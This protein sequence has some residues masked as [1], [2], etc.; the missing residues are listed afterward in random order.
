MTEQFLDE[1]VHITEIRSLIGR[2]LGPSQPTILDQGRI[3]L[4]ADATGDR[5]WIHTDPNRAAE[6]ATG[7]TIAHGFLILALA[8]TVN[9]E[10]VPIAGTASR[11]NYGLNKVR[12]ISPAPAGTTARG[13]TTLESVESVASGTQLIFEIEI[14]GD[15]IE[16]PLCIA[17]FIS[18][19]PG[20]HL[21]QEPAA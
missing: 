1:A 15:E 21:E 16:K 3:D 18:L 4:F 2:R 12:F 19:A 8:A 7:S 11:V 9:Q 20:V 5:Q 13:Y 6:T 10:L 14:R 17:Q